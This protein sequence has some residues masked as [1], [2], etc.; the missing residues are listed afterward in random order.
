MRWEAGKRGKEGC[1]GPSE[2][3]HSV[4]SVGLRVGASCVES[5]GVKDSW[6]PG[7]ARSASAK[8]EKEVNAPRQCQIL[9]KSFWCPDHGNFL[10]EQA[11]NRILAERWHEVA[12]LIL[13][14]F[15]LSVGAPGFSVGP[16]GWW[17]QATE[18]QPWTLPGVPEGV[19]SRGRL[20]SPILKQ[21][22]PC[23]SPSAT[24][25]VRDAQRLWHFLSTGWCPG[26]ER[27]LEVGMRPCSP[28]RSCPASLSLLCPICL[29]GLSI[30]DHR[31]LDSASPSAWSGQGRGVLW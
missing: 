1:A 12:T 4:A 18:S 25:W 26:C 2:G 27:H 3:T 7:V 11:G 24:T 29:L 31:C 10:F 20:S 13:H 17:I 23:L 5:K 8:V 22:P 6:W 19:L 28:I 9:S 14:L 21:Q 30:S 15:I 16:H